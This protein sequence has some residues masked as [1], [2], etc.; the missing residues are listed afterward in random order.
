[1]HFF[2]DLAVARDKEAGGIPEQAAKL[3]SDGVITLTGQNGSQF[4]YNCEFQGIANASLAIQNVEELTWCVET[5]EAYGRALAATGSP[6][7][8]GVLSDAARLSGELVQ[9]RR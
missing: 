9:A 5:L 7:A 3:V 1:M 2:R 4:S 6:A 8:E